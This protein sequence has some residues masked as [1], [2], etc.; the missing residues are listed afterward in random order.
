MPFSVLIVEE[1]QFLRN[2]L[3]HFFKEQFSDESDWVTAVSEAAEFDMTQLKKGENLDLIVY[4]I[5]ALQDVQDD[6]RKALINRSLFRAS[7]YKKT[8]DSLKDHML[9]CHSGDVTV[10]VDEPDWDPRLARKAKVFLCS[11]LVNGG[12]D[13]LFNERDH[14]HPASPYEGRF[15]RFSAHGKELTYTLFKL[16]GAITDYWNF[17]DERT[18]KRVEAA[19]SC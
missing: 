12:L 18:K 13:A 14:R 1:N 4:G 5:P 10:A 8:G 16:I 7:Y 19:V 15:R 9:S 3:T 11:Q 6:A 2:V 17:L